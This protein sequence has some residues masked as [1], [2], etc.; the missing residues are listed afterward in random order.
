MMLHGSTRTK[1]QRLVEEL[2]PS[3]L[4]NAVPDLSLTSVGPERNSSFRRQ[5]T[6]DLYERQC[7]RGRA[8]LV[9]AQKSV[10]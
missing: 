4:F 2:L 6:S 1:L 5:T 10:T 9:T 3:M 8:L 7:W